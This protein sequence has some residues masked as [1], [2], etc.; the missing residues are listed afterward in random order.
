MFLLFFVLL[1]STA[2][3]AADIVPLF[4]NEWLIEATIEA[5]FGQIM[6]ERS[7]DQELD[8]VFSYKNPDGSEQRLDSKIRIRGNYRAR[9]DIC[10]FAPL[11]LNFRKKQ[12]AGTEFAGQNKL[13]LVTH[14]ENSGKRP[15][16]LVLK[17]YLTYKFLAALTENSFDTRLL[18]VTY[19]DSDRPAKSRTKYAFLIEEK[20]KLADRIGA[21]LAKVESIQFDE[22]NHTQTNLVT[23]YSYFIGNTDFSATRGP[24]K[25]F[26]CHNIVLF[27]QE[28][29]IKLPIPYDFD[30]SGMVD[31]PYAA[32]NPRLKINFVTTRLYR[33]LC[34][35]NELLDDTFNLFHE[36]RDQFYA[37]ISG[38]QGLSDKS[39]KKMRKFLDDFYVT[40]NDESLVNRSFVKRCSEATAPPSQT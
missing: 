24:G 11:R 1:A 37:L 9:K 31:A 27:E 10:D 8:G 18:R 32:P 23:V 22:L 30:F 38:L 39:K 33:G 14:C 40:V 28:P 34:R 4:D 2:V 3:K 13:K 16:Q 26:C 12:V 17:E 5:P 36:R 6:R 19:V 29:G 21:R 20:E 35:N 15:E 7:E 25:G